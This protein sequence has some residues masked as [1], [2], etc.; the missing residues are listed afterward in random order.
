MEQNKIITQ[1]LEIIIQKL[2]GLPQ[3][4]ITV[5]RRSEQPQFMPIQRSIDSEEMFQKV[6]KSSVF[7]IDQREEREACEMITRSGRVLEERRVEKR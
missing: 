7:Y 2:S 4:M 3:E 1:Q 5:P 6:M